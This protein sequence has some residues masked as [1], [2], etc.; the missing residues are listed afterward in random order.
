[1]V[2]WAHPILMEIF[3]FKLWR[4]FFFNRK[5]SV[6]VDFYSRT[7]P[8]TIIILFKHLNRLYRRITSPI[9]MQK[10]RIVHY[11]K[12]APRTWGHE[13]RTII[14]RSHFTFLSY[15]LYQNSTKIEQ[16]LRL[17]INYY[18]PKYG[19]PLKFWY[20]KRAVQ[21]T[22]SMLLNN[23]CWI[24][25]LKRKVIINF[26]QHAKITLKLIGKNTRVSLLY[27]YRF[28]FSKLLDIVML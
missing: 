14:L 19:N 8:P 27:C 15:R 16:I 2:G 6:D 9:S 26:A 12:F 28:F 13:A 24:F 4:S 18:F 23:E 21:K 25:I 7:S 20:S 5:C 10:I 22:V 1:M 3:L 11:T 17:S